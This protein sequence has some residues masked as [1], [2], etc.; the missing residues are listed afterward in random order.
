[1][2]FSGTLTFEVSEGVYLFGIMRVSFYVNLLI[3]LRIYYLSDLFTYLFIRYPT[4]RL[5]VT[6]H[7]LSGN[8]HLRPLE[9]RWYGTVNC[10][11][12]EDSNLQRLT[13][14]GDEDILSLLLLLWKKYSNSPSSR[15][16]QCL[17]L[18]DPNV[19]S[20]GENERNTRVRRIGEV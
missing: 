5:V 14:S 19:N 11:L 4:F 6:V 8:L 1:M 20:K 3:S 12:D 16:P 18:T 10:R 17:D 15:A 7:R 2:S 9:P 13:W